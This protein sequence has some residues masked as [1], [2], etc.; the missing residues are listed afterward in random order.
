MHI[1]GAAAAEPLPEVL[2][3]FEVVKQNKTYKYKIN[4]HHSSFIIHA[5][6]YNSSATT[7]L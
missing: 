7:I 1:R 3:Y 2:F 6:P 5:E 4:T